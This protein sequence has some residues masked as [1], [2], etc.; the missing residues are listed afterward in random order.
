MTVAL[1]P[2]GVRHQS[3]RRAPLFALFLLAMASTA[4]ASCPNMCS[5]RGVC[6]EDDV[7]ECYTGFKGGDCSLRTCGAGIY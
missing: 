2:G 3:A 6:F 5:N 1:L 7:C 4:L